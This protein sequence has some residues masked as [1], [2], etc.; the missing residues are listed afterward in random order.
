MSHN[1]IEDYERRK[2]F[3]E[4]LNTLNKVEQ[5]EVF[6]ILKKNSSLFSENSNGIFFDVS[7]IDKSTFSQLLTFIEFCKK[8]REEFESREQEQQRAS[9][10]LR[11]NQ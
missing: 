1:D 7:R 8:N 5:E 6:R 4:D 3:L 11:L 10:A 2:A 9:E